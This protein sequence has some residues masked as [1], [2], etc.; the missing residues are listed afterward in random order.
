MIVL[1]TADEPVKKG[2]L[3]PMPRRVG[4]DH[5]FA[6]SAN[7]IDLDSILGD[8]ESPAPP[9]HAVSEDVEVDLSIS[10]DTIK[11]DAT[12]STDG[13]FA[14]AGRDLSPA[15]SMATARGITQGEAPVLAN[16]YN[17]NVSHMMD[18]AKTLYGANSGTAGA[19]T[20]N[21]TARTLTADTGFFWFFNSANVELVVKILDGRSINGNFWVFYGALSDVA[22]TLT[23]TDTQ[24]NRTKTFTNPQGTLASVADTAALPGP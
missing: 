19:I 12:N 8:F 6:M 3:K 4:E 16:Q 20:G 7:A 22:Y 24:T 11:N 15:N 17:T 14:A 21:G 1:P 5:H 23:I 10:L 2:P 13:A 9:V 18:A